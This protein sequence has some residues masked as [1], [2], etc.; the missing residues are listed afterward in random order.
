MGT[1]VENK[2]LEIINTILENR[3]SKILTELRPEMH[4]RNDIGLD[5]LGLAE[6]TV[7]I[8]LEY[9]IDIFEDGLIYNISDILKKLNI[10]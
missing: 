8:E 2:I 7:R 10:K 4:L 3:N 9:D 5:S 1:N 6:L